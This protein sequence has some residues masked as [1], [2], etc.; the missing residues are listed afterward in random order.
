ME[1][2]QTE[3]KN[4]NNKF[5]TWFKTSITARLL[6]MGALVLLL[7][8]PLTLIQEL[9]K[10]REQRQQSVVNELNDKWGNEILLYGPILKVPYKTYEETVKYDEE[11]KKTFKEQR[12]ILKYGYFF[13]N[14]LDIT[15]DVKTSKKKRNNFDTA[16]FTSEIAASGSFETPDF[17][18]KSIAD[19]DIVWEKATLLIKTTNLKGLKSE[20][21]L[22][23]NGNVYGFET[24]FNAQHNSYPQLDE[25]EST[26][27]A[28]A[29]VPKTSA[30]AFDFKL[31]Y[32][33]SKSIK[34]IPIGKVTNVQ[35]TSDWKDPSHTGNFITQSE[36]VTENG[37]FEAN[38]KL[39]NTNRS[40]SQQFFQTLP[41][42]N[43][44]A[45]GTKFII[46]LDEYQKSERSAKYG[47]LVIGLT[48]LVF[49]LIQTLSKIS[50]HPFQYLMI[51]IALVMFYTLLISISEHSS[52]L[53][54]YLIAGIAVIVMITLYSKSILKNWKFPLFIGTSLT[55]L[56][57]FIFVIIQ[58]ENYALLVGS[59]G[60]FLILGIVM[61]VSRKIDWGFDSAQPANL[62]SQLATNS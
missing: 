45:F 11:T 36:R 9:I 47:F 34:F 26:H 13:P 4:S 22:N 29:D 2:H 18:S 59:I 38:W 14:T 5:L 19:E 57:G 30:Q 42:L 3:K 43:Q 35:M 55:A 25:L 40:F 20:V 24:N 54:A 15:A 12:T 58:L 61:F 21:K 37:G 46:P 27:I 48:F 51:G 41:N 53:K 62:N 60:L 33:G 16:V 50:I 28:L 56:Y 52:F 32:N 1:A 7:M 6:V 31:M 49:F 17:L 23:L 39:L 8:I 10:E 44:Y